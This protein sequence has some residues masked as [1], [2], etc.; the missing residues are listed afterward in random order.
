MPQ[1]HWSKAELEAP[2][3]YANKEIA[4]SQSLFYLPRAGNIFLNCILTNQI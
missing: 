2:G 1:S 3:K 4:Q